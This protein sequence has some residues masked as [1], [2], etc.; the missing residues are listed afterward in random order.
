MSDTTM[1]SDEDLDKFIDSI[2]TR[3]THKGSV[4]RI[5]LELKER[6]AKALHEAEVRARI[7]GEIALAR[8]VLAVSGGHNKLKGFTQAKRLKLLT[9]KMNEIIPDIFGIEEVDVTLTAEKEK[10]V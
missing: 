9:D 1:P 6:V 5:R 10:K 7:E 2:I 8:K 3:E 4:N